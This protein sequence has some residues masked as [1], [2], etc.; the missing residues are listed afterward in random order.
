MS[1]VADNGWS[2]YSNDDGT[3][4]TGTS[5]DETLLNNFRDSIDGIIH[6][7]TNPTIDVSAAIDELVEGRGNKANIDARI[8]GVID[9]DGALITPA[10]L[11]SE[12]NLKSGL[13]SVNLCTNEEA[14]IWPIT[15]VADAN[16][17]AHWGFTDGGGG[18]DTVALSGGA[19]PKIKMGGAF[20]INRVSAGGLNTSLHQ[21]IVS[22]AAWNNDLRGL[23]FGLGCWV[24][25]NIASHAKV[26]IYDGNDQTSAIHTG[27]EGWEWLQVTHTID[28]AGTYL[29]VYLEVMSNG[30]AYFA[31]PTLAMGNYAPDRWWPSPRIAGQ[32]VWELTGL[33]ATGDDQRRFHAFRPMLLQGAAVTCAND[34]TGNFQIDIMKYNS[35]PAWNSVFDTAPWTAL[36]S[37]N[38]VGSQDFDKSDSSTRCLQGTHKASGAQTTDTNSTIR[39]DIDAVNA[40]EDITIGIQAMQY[41]PYFEGNLRV[42]ND[43]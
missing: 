13:G 15:T 6:S 12:T 31:L 22:V 16:P 27:V 18:S 14:L 30:T 28:G 20:E 41:L 8:S 34:P 39:L 11:I 21:S 3:G 7:T 9:D 24:Y 5:I 2:G 19:D 25:T 26:T 10:S 23:K 36:A 29:G 17:P 32:I 43:I 40:A 33:P 4:Q 38:E 35:T 1:K 42:W 37:G